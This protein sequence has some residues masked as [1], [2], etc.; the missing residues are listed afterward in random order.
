VQYFDTDKNG[1]FDK[2]TYD[3]DEDRKDDLVINLLEYGKDSQALHNP[4]EIKWEGMHKLYKEISLKS[5]EDGLKLYRALWKKGLA[6]A[7]MNDLSFASS[8]GDQYNQ[9]YWM[10]EKIF[11]LLD[12]RFEGDKKKQ[13]ALRKAH[14]TGDIA[15]LIKIIDEI[16]V[17]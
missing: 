10:Q 3:Y 15:G 9:G 8:V 17:P 1:F 7:E 2:I 16:Q 5:F 12:K 13:A 14:F 6:T 11:R 4:G